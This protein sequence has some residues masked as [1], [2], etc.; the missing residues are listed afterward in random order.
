LIDSTQCR[1]SRESS[2]GPTA[3]RVTARH[4]STTRPGSSS[5]LTF[6]QES[7]CEQSTVGHRGPIA[8]PPVAGRGPGKGSIHAIL[9]RWTLQRLNLAAGPEAIA[10]SQPELA[11]IPAGAIRQMEASVPVS[12]CTADRCSVNAAHAT[13][14]P[15]RGRG[16]RQGQ[17]QSHDV[18]SPKRRPRR[19]TDQGS[20][21]GKRQTKDRFLVLRAEPS[22]GRRRSPRATVAQNVGWIWRG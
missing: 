13:P 17:P 15:Q 9:R 7:S 5:F 4:I 21:R 22:T 18:S 8:G 3:S 20:V 19:P 1:G 14:R 6:H 12:A 2:P 10:Q 11:R 16:Q